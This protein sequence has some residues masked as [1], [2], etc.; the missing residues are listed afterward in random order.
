MQEMKKIS[1]PLIVLACLFCGCK[2]LSVQYKTLPAEI[3]F[4]DS[5]ASVLLIDAAEIHTPGIAIRKK[6]EEVVTQVKNDFMQELP[7]AISKD[8]GNPVLKNVQLNEETVVRLL[9]DDPAVCQKVMTDHQVAMIIILKDCS[10]GFKQD[11]VVKEK[12]A[13]GNTSKK[14]YYSV[15]FDTYVHIKQKERSWDKTVSASKQHSSRTVLSGLLARGPGYQA[16]K[17]SIAAMANENMHKLTALFREQK[18]AVN[19]W[20]K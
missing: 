7:G 4:P 10:G 15:F 17:K 9:N 8:L 19:G 2:V 11:E 3:P 16:N 6:R 1:I 13:D 18:V 14:A 20:T 12:D 5:T